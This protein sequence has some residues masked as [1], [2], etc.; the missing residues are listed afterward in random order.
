MHGRNEGIKKT[1]VWKPEL[2]KCL[3]V[4]IECPKFVIFVS[5]LLA[6]FESFSGRYIGFWFCPSLTC[7]RTQHQVLK[8]NLFPCGSTRKRTLS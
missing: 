4:D 8:K 1:L 3:P 6:G 5:E 7:S 2:K